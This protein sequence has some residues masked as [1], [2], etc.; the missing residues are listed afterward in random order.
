MA[1]SRISPPT[2]FNS[3]PLVRLLAGL[4]IANVADSTQTFAE[5][6]S[7]WVAWTDAISLSSALDGGPAAGAAVAKA[8]GSSEANK[9]IEQFTQVRNELMQSIAHD[10]MFAGEPAGKARPTAAAGEVD[11]AIYRR[12]YLTSQ[13]VMDERVS[14]LRGHVR[15]AVALMSPAFSRLASLDAAMEQAL[16]AHQRRLLANVPLLLEKRFKGLCKAE[17]EAQGAGDG[18]HPVTQHTS[19]A[20][21]GAM[22]QRVLQAELGMRLQPVQGMIDALGGNATRQA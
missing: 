9:V 16:G 21:V 4:D 8:G 14:S 2:S 1:Q 15:A 6:L 7:Q 18:P 10:A 13:R 20:A 17:L 12:H 3:S 19:A 11:F 5:K 22:L